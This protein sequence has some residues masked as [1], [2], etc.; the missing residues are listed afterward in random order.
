MI[1]GECYWVVYGGCD[2]YGKFLI[3]YFDCCVIRYV[4][5]GK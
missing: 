3:K 4:G 2:I 1:G 5:V